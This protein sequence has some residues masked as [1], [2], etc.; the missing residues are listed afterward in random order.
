VKLP[1]D[2]APEEP[3]WWRKPAYFDSKAPTPSPKSNSLL[4][5]DRAPAHPSDGMWRH[6]DSGGLSR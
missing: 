2:F 5:G 4:G 3:L 1:T 6:Y